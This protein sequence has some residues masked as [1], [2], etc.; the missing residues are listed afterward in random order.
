MDPLFVNLLTF[1]AGLLLGHWLS[2]GRDKRKEFNEVA[3]RVRAVFLGER[4]SPS[5]YRKPVSSEDIDL[6]TQVLP[7]WK[8]QGFRRALGRYNQ[9]KKSAETQNE[10]GE[11]LYSST[12]A[13]KEAAEHVL[14][15]TKR[16]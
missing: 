7:T 16:A 3:Q 15:Y 13:I 11:V 10:C 9:A 5:P 2:L 8:R 6:F 12:D 14:S 4:E 1:A